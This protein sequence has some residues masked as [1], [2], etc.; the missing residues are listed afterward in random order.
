[1][2]LLVAVVV[3][4]VEVLALLVAREVELLSLVNVVVGKL[5][6]DGVGLVLFVADAFFPLFDSSTSDFPVNSVSL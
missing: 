4:M 3:V 2:L 5:D 6:D 1:M